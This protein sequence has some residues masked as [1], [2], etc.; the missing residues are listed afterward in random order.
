MY[1]AVLHTPSHAHRHPAHLLPYTISIIVFTQGGAIQSGFHMQSTHIRVVSGSSVIQHSLNMKTQP[2]GSSHYPPP[3]LVYSW[4][5]VD[6]D[7]SLEFWLLWCEAFLPPNSGERV[8]EVLSEEIGVWFK[9]SRSW[10]S[11]ERTFFS[12]PQWWVSGISLYL[13]PRFFAGNVSDS[14]LAWLHLVRE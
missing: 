14:A 8:N 9:Q 4:R 13:D 6:L 10:I 1:H 2:R 3:C 12:F 5:V 11:F 7:P